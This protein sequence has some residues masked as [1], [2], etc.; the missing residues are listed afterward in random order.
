MNA[1]ASSRVAHVRNRPE[2]AV[3]SA[4]TPWLLLPRSSS[5]ALTTAIGVKRQCAPRTMPP[6]RSRQA[7]TA[8]A[9]PLTM[10]IGHCARRCA[11]PALGDLRASG[12]D[13]PARPA[14]RVDAQASDARRPRVKHKRRRERRVGLAHA[15]RHARYWA[16][17]Q[18]RDSARRRMPAWPSGRA[19]GPRPRSRSLGQ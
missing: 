8:P 14:A 5:H 16:N 15:D 3:G 18:A 12:G 2:R 11:S 9:C 13:P 6:L 10:Q 7:V 1:S 17:A 4:R 19:A